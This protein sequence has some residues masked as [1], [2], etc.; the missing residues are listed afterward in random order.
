MAA[1]VTGE[2][3]SL[4]LITLLLDTVDT[5][6]DIATRARLL[7]RIR[8]TLGHEFDLRTYRMV[9]ELNHTHGWRQ[10]DIAD[11]LGVSASTVKMWAQRHRDSLG[12]PR[13]DYAERERML[14]DAVEIRSGFKG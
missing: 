14:A 3:D 6:P 1:Y 13:T 11:A 9:Y 12:I 2:R 5:V 7:A 10:V 8:Q 4:A